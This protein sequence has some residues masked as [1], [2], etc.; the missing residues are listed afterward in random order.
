MCVRS[1]GETEGMRRVLL[2]W[3]AVMR[4]LCGPAHRSGVVGLHGSSAT[5]VDGQECF[6]VFCGALGAVHFHQR[7]QDDAAAELAGAAARAGAALTF[8]HFLGIQTLEPSISPQESS[9]H[10]SPDCG[11]Q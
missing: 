9:I 3:V 8:N 2:R 10:W 5:C 1:A 11:R 4:Q 6:G 7:A